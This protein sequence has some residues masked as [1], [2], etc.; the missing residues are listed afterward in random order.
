MSLPRD[1]LEQATHLANREPKRPKQ[2]SLRRA[3]SSAYYAL[4]HL[5]IHDS[6]F[7]AAPSAPAGLRDLVGRAF[8]HTEMKT[9]CKGFVSGNAAYLKSIAPGARKAFET[10]D[11]PPSTQKILEFPLEED[12]VLVMKAFVDLQEAR[13][14]ADYNTT[15]TF[16]RVDVLIKIKLAD[17]AFI[18]WANVRSK[19]NATV[20]KMALLLQRQWGR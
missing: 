18:A 17:D 6:A 15:A 8:G 12:I 7:D 9:V 5:L 14:E 10:G 2:A 1:L 11:I 3:L 16:N 13:H 19:P 20:F 4:F